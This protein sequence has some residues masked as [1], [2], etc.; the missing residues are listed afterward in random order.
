MSNNKTVKLI[1]KDGVVFGVVQTAGVLHQIVDSS[2]LPSGAA[3]ASKQLASG[4][5]VAITGYTGASQQY[6]R[7]D[8]STFALNAIEYAHHEV[9]AKHSF[10]C[11]YTQLVSDTGDKSIIAFKTPNGTAHVHI[12]VEIASQDGA[13][14]YILEAPTITDNAGATL[15]VFNRFRDGVLVASGVI[16]TSQNPDAANAA[17]FFTEAT[18]GAVTGGTKLQEIQMIVGQGP[19]I[20]GGSARGSQ[21]WVLKKNTLYAFVIESLN[22][23]DNLHN[24]RLDFYEH[25]PE[26]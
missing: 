15:T 23:N 16:D 25:A 19:R 24:I 3:I 14:A 22:A 7:L 9:H 17:T 5:D 8:P 12:I 18:M 21:E 4:H 1:D 6:L 20:L 13:L 2:A 11:F 10:S 26:E